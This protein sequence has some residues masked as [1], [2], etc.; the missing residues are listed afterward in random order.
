MV[1]L[2]DSIQMYGRSLQEH[3][4]RVTSTC[5]TE[6]EGSQ[7]Q[8]AAVVG[9]GS[10]DVE[11]QGDARGYNIREQ[12]S[13]RVLHAIVATPRYLRTEMFSCCSMTLPNLC[14]RLG[15]CFQ[16]AKANQMVVSSSSEK[17]LLR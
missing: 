11:S 6:A 16:K 12:G 8:W 4:S 3:S 1:R 15:A 7:Q 13:T 17:G 9:P 2:I 14:A 5:N 10:E